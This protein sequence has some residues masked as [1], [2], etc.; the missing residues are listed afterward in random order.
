MLKLDKYQ[1]INVRK[2]SW[3]EKQHIR[4]V[5]TYSLIC[6]NKLAF[7]ALFFILPQFTEVYTIYTQLP[8]PRHPLYLWL[9]KAQETQNEI[10]RE[11]LHLGLYSQLLQSS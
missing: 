1:E 6:D 5:S 3:Q 2:S 4:A 8:I 9:G 10:L 11:S 7:N